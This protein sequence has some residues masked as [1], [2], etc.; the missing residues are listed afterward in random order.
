MIS[1]IRA[2]H[3]E[4]APDDQAY[5]LVLTH[6]EIVWAVAE[7]L[8]HARGLEV[9]VELVRAGC[10][11][12]DVGVHLL[13]GSPYIRHGVLGARALLERGFPAEL[14]RFCAHH[15]GVGLTREDIERQNLPLPAGDYLAETAE[16]R[17]V[18]YADKFH[19]KSTPPVFVTAATYASRIGRFGAGPAARFAEMVAYYG[20]PDLTELTARYPH[21]VL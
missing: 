4:L 15:T 11:V 14:A 10:L 16:E 20:E 3:R 2:L 18:M 19:S 7:Q 13:A 9:D 21:A 17:L 12:H 1:R 8:V 5:E 6:C